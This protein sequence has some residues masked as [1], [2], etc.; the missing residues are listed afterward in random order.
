MLTIRLDLFGIEHTVLRPVLVQTVKDIKKSLGITKDIYTRF[1]SRETVIK[2]KN[3]VGE[4]IGRNTTDSNMIHIEYED[5]SEDQYDLPIIQYNPDM[6]PIYRDPEIGSSIIP[7]TYLR[8]LNITFKYLSKSR[9]AMEAMSNS[10]RLK[11]SYTGFSLDHDLEYHYVIPNFAISLLGEINRLKNIRREEKLTLYEYVQSTF[12]SRLDLTTTRDGVSQ[13]L[14]IREAQCNVFGYCE[15]D[16]H[17]IK[18]E[19]DD[20]LGVWY[21]EFQYFLVYEKPISLK[22]DYPLLVFNTL[23][24]EKYRDFIP[25]SNV[26]R[27]AHYRGSVSS[28]QKLTDERGYIRVSSPY[29][30]VRVPSVDNTLLKYSVMSY[31]P[32][33]S[34]LVILDESDTTL[35]CN[36]KDIPDV[37][38][39]PNVI[40]FML[41]EGKRTAKHLNS[42]FYFALFSGNN[43]ISTPVYLNPNGDLVAG[44]P[45][46]LRQTYRVMIYMARDLDFLRDA[47]IARF[48]NFICYEAIKAVPVEEPITFQQFRH[49]FERYTNTYEVEVTPTPS[50]IDMYL[51]TMSVGDYYYG[52]HDRFAPKDLVFNIMASLLSRKEAGLLILARMQQLENAQTSGNGRQDILENEDI[53]YNPTYDS[54]ENVASDNSYVMVDGVLIPTE[55]LD[56]AILPD[57]EETP[58]KP[59]KPDGYYDLSGVIVPPTPELTE[60]QKE[61]NK[62]LEYLYNKLKEVINSLVDRGE[63]P[64]DTT[65]EDV[66]NKDV[67]LPNIDLSGPIEPEVEEDKEPPLLP[68]P[69]TEDN[70]DIEI[71]PGMDVVPEE[72]LPETDTEVD[73]P[74]VDNEQDLP[75][76]LDDLLQE[77]EG[78]DFI[79]PEP[80]IPPRHPAI[81]IVDTEDEDLIYVPNIAQSGS[82]IIYTVIGRPLMRTV[83][84]SSIITIME[85]RTVFKDK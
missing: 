5:A 53:E 4:I 3:K 37:Q 68:K 28:I 78:K 27:R 49:K 32:M 10:L 22:V 7:I 24:G 65:L 33:V 26:N 73:T 18:T 56:D 82:P 58:V 81:E 62:R 74:T 39:K 31:V 12:D 75:P 51:T 80:P 20:S 36:I 40:D 2:K 15:D 77:V 54:V 6:A 69:D 70:G 44:E 17:N 19:Y 60:E 14:V 72:I 23:I 11:S 13:D 64:P 85:Q 66:L 29:N 79:T 76:T 21:I 46:D 8:R 57:K 47:A 43:R 35:L 83:Q 50:L 34:I 84:T 59:S 1:D 63:I 41:Q 16:L 67:I 38:F 48:V 61:H 9:S 52:L 25:M 30:Y 42:V 55:H 45:L 71:D